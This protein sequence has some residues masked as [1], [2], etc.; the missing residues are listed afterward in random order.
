[1]NKQTTLELK[2]D[3][4][5]LYYFTYRDQ[6]GEFGL[7]NSQD[8]LYRIVKDKRGMEQSDVSVK[9]GI[10]VKDILSF[11]DLQKNPD[12]ILFKKKEFINNLKYTADRLIKDRV[13]RARLINLLDNIF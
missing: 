11:I 7:A 6:I 9:G 3:S 1:M 12:P 13:K 8:D 5:W 2:I 4:L 10:P